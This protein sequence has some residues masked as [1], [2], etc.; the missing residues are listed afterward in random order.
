MDKL[1]FVMKVTPPSFVFWLVCHDELYL[2]TLRERVY[3][4]LSLRSPEHFTFALHFLLHFWI[5]ADL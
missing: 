1:G 4:L 5:V 3:E 2:P